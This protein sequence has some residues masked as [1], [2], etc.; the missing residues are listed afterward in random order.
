MMSAA[1]TDC[2]A[3]AAL[4]RNVRTLSARHYRMA[5]CA[6]DALFRSRRIRFALMRKANEQAKTVLPQFTKSIDPAAK[7]EGLANTPIGSCRSS[8]LELFA[9]TAKEG[10]V[11]STSGEIW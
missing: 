5:I 4:L 7:L 6:R 1:T 2:R 9:R 8:Q 11:W 10:M 3:H